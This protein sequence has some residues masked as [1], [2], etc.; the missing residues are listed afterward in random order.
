VSGVLG[1][2]ALVS[3]GEEVTIDGNAVEASALGSK[4]SNLASIEGATV[5]NG[6]AGASNSQ[7]HTSG[8]VNAIASVATLGTTSGAASTANNLTIN[9]NSVQTS[10]QGATASNR[11]SV[12]AAG[13]MTDPVASAVNGQQHL[14]GDTS[15][16]TIVGLVGSQTPLSTND[17]LVVK[18]NHLTATAGS[19]SASNL[20]TLDA[21]SLTASGAGAGAAVSNSQLH[22][23]GNV[24]AYVGSTQAWSPAPFNPAPTMVGAANGAAVGGTALVSGN[25]SVADANINLAS[26]GVA[27]QGSGSIGGVNVSGLANNQTVESGNA[28]AQVKVN[29]GITGARSLGNQAIVSD[30]AS[31]ASA[32]QNQAVNDVAVKAGNALSSVTPVLASIQNS[33]GNTS[34]TVETS[35]LTGVGIANLSNGDTTVSNNTAS[36]SARANVANNSISISSG[37]Q[38]TSLS[39]SLDNKQTNTGGASAG[40]NLQIPVGSLLANQALGSAVAV[41]GNSA[42]SLGVGNA[43]LNSIEAGA[44]TALN[45]STQFALA[46]TQNNYGPINAATTLNVPVVSSGSSVNLLNNTATAS[47]FGNSAVNQVTLTAMPSQLVASA[48]LTSTQLNTG[49]V[50][51]VVNGDFTH[52]SGGGSTGSINISGNRGI[53]VAVGNSS[54]S[55]MTIGVK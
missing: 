55:S 11:A 52:T 49:A 35:L 33:G 14:A 28:A 47:A 12:Q 21:S 22:R 27:I 54:T 7:T 26:N 4:A 45:G 5:T 46:N 51:A 29:Y 44:G 9:G 20:A 34:A 16:M 23:G 31:Q 37:A 6:I 1:R 25:S 30:N 39:G 18:G 19:Q 43:A 17:Q 32:S 40:T 15:A 3:V 41:T 10:A 50:T 8:G 38:T 2:N 24:T 13:S 53:A 36:S 48:T 42:S